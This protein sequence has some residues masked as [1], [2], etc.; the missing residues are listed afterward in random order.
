MSCAKSFKRKEHLTLT[1]ISFALKF[2]PSIQQIR[3]ILL[4]RI[5]SGDVGSSSHPICSPS[6]AAVVAAPLAAAGGMV[7]CGVLPEKDTM[8]DGYRDFFLFGSH[9]D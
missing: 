9:V 6:L 7:A 5:H 1:T 3:G 2:H 8:G 4:T